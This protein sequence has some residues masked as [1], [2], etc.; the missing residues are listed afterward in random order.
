VTDDRTPETAFH[1]LVA[2]IAHELRTPLTAIR[3]SAGLLLAPD[4]APTEEQRQTLLETIERNADRMQRVVGDILDLARF[5]AGTLSLQLRGFDAVALARGAIDSLA[6]VAAA[7]GVAIDLEAPDRVVSTFGD[8]RRL[9]QVLVNLL[10]NAVRFSPEGGR[11]TV[12][13]ATDAAWL[14]IAVTDRGPGIAAADQHRLFERFFVGRSDRSGPRDG[15]G[16]GLPIALEI[17]RAHGGHVEVESALGAGSTFVLV[18]PIDGPADPDAPDTPA[19][20]DVPDA[21]PTV[22]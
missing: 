9:E 22:D 3:T 8:R 20:P 19:D 21:T 13:I 11:V 5:R 4:T 2:T 17:A 7:R 10:S 16:L 1:D 14:R 18:L 12:S 15:V 6:L